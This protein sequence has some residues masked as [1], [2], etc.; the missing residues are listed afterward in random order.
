MVVEIYLWTRQNCCVSC[1]LWSLILELRSSCHKCYLPLKHTIASYHFLLSTLL[2]GFL[3]FVVFN[4]VPVHGIHVPSVWSGFLRRSRSVCRL[5]VWSWLVVFEESSWRTDATLSAST[6]K[7]SPWLLVWFS[8]NDARTLA[9]QCEIQ[10][11]R[12]DSF[13]L[14]S[15]CSV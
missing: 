10:N 14:K 7:H 13:F 5:M 2:T 3:C 4:G 12:I 6:S 15:K 8:T 11:F 1:Q 9:C